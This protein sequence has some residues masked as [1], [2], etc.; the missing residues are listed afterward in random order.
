VELENILAVGD[1]TEAQNLL[2]D[3]SPETNIQENFKSFY[4]LYYNYRTNAAISAAEKGLLEVLCYQ[5]PFSDGPAVYKAR[6]LWNLIYGST[7]SYYDDECTPEGYSSRTGKIENITELDNLTER[8][9][10]REIKN[11]KQKNK[12]DYKIYPNP[13]TD[14][15]S[16]TGF[17]KDERIEVII[18]EVTGRELSR[19]I[20]NPDASLI[21]LKVELNNGIYFVTLINSK[22]EKLVKKLIISK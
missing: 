7:P 2:E 11:K 9:E 21:N 18:S 20:A 12:S 4:Q 10:A 14:E 19:Q 17:Q 16:I 13:A 22:K 15:I 1:Y 3:F 5:C 6:A 8:L